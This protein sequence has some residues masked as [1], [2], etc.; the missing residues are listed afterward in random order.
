MWGSV[1]RIRIRI[2]NTNPDPTSYPITDSG[3]GSGSRPMLFR[4]KFFFKYLLNLQKKKPSLILV[5]IAGW[6]WG[7]LGVRNI[8]LPTVSMVCLV[9]FVRKIVNFSNFFKGSGSVLLT[10]LFLHR[11]GW[12]MKDVNLQVK[13]IETG[14]QNRSFKLWSISVP[15]R[16]KVKKCNFK[17]LIF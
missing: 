8:F 2:H 9:N 1:Y 5:V 13:K 4:R 14:H 6:L 15:Y 12:Q 11:E 16:Q 7:A 10:Y 17:N 3:F